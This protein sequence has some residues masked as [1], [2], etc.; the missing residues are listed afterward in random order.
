MHKGIPWEQSS[1]TSAYK[2]G[3]V[4]HK[5]DI[6]TLQR[7]A[8]KAFTAGRNLH[9]FLT[10]QQFLGAKMP[11]NSPAGEVRSQERGGASDC[12]SSLPFGSHNLYSW[13]IQEGLSLAEIDCRVIAFR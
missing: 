13:G 7:L 11:I 2:K 9:R 5:Q 4:H 10:Q 8:G 6:T 3:R 12:C 1:D